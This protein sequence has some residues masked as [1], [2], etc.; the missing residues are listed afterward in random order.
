MLEFHLLANSKQRFLFLRVR[1]LL[2][3]VTSSPGTSV[4]SSPLTCEQAAAVV[5]GMKHRQRYR[6]VC[7]E[8][9]RIHLTFSPCNPNIISR[10]ISRNDFESN[11]GTVLVLLNAAN[12]SGHDSLSAAC[13]HTLTSAGIPSSIPM[14]M[15][16]LISEQVVL[17]LTI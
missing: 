4:T 8:R 6:S 1:R 5:M 15:P 12:L 3:A 10:G 16:T 14:Q 17:Y 11:C 13:S 2:L 7:R 9:P